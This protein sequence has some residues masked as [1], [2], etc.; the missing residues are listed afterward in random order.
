MV[1]AYA[2]DKLAV[3]NS[4]RAVHL[5]PINM[6]AGRIGL[7]FDASDGGKSH[8]TSFEMLIALR[9]AHQT[10]QAATGTRKSVSQAKALTEDPKSGLSAKQLE[11]EKSDKQRLIRKFADIIK[12]Y[13]GRGASTGEDRKKRWQGV[14]ATGNAANAA[15][16]A[17]GRSKKVAQ[18]WARQK[19]T[20]C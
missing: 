10:K 18:L 1:A 13:E 20:P 12:E 2:E 19:Y 3:S 4:F 15:K 14:P 9:R 8:S 5:P 16:A 17:D 7:S 6:D 11:S